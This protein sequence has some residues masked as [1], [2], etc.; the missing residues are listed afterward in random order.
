MATKKLFAPAVPRSVLGYTVLCSHCT[1]LCFAP[2]MDM[3]GFT[4]VYIGLYI[5]RY[6]HSSSDKEVCGEGWAVEIRE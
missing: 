2:C 4:L 6:D 5:Y 1:L 3:H